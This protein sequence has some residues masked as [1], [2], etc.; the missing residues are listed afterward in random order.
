MITVLLV[1]SSYPRCRVF[2]LV[3]LRTACLLA[4]PFLAGGALTRT[5]AQQERNQPR[6]CGKSRGWCVV[7]SSAARPQVVVAC[8]LWLAA[9]R[10]VIV[11]TVRCKKTRT[12]CFL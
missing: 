9:A 4:P 8:C 3:V 2:F 12:L 11:T 1:T 7:V 5:A 10:F 6:P